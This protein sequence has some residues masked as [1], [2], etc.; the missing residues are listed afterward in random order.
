MVSTVSATAAAAAAAGSPVVGVPDT[1]SAY[2]RALAMVLTDLLCR[3]SAAVV[4]CRMQDD[5]EGS[6]TLRRIVRHG[7]EAAWLICDT[8]W[9]RL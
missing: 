2:D 5:A 6:E 8:L 9:N 7:G 4:I 3:E 1:L